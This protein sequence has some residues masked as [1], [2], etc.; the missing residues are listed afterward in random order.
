M[1]TQAVASYRGHRE[2]NSYGPKPYDLIKEASEEVD[3][4]NKNK[5]KKAIMRKSAF[6]SK[7][8]LFELRRRT[9]FENLMY[10]H[11]KTQAAQSDCLVL[12][13]K[14]DFNGYPQ[15]ICKSQFSN[16]SKRKY[17]VYLGYAPRSMIAGQEIRGNITVKNAFKKD[18]RSIRIGYNSGSYLSDTQLDKYYKLKRSNQ[19]YFY[20]I[21]DFDDIF[22]AQP[23][24][25]TSAELIL[26]FMNKP[27]YTMNYNLKKTKFD[28]ILYLLNTTNSTA[29]LSAATKN[30]TVYVNK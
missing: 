24:N 21:L 23:K 5:T 30:N 12:F 14:T 10:W 22:V 18:K 1:D 15:L 19:Q 17:R 2:H 9:A 8:K 27:P 6:G 29:H 26:D 3:L 11:N 20:I 28:P 16:P 4:I 13:R 25:L 7:K